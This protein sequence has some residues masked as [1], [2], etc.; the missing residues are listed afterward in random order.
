[1]NRRRFGIVG[2]GESLIRTGRN[3]KGNS[4]NEGRFKVRG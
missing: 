1:M 4:K 2:G 3:L